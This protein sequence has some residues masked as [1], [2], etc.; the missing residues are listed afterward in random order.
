MVKASVT[1]QTEKNT[2]ATGSQTRNQAMALSSTP[3]VISTT[4]AG[5]TTNDREKASTTMQTV[6]SIVANFMKIRLK[7]KGPLPG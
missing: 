3:P 7:V 5:L 1:T 6:T 4:A 2:M